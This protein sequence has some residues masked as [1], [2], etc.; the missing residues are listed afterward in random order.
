MTQRTTRDAPMIFA[1]VEPE[2][3]AAAQAIADEKYEGNLSMVVRDA[4]R[5]Y[6]ARW[7]K[8]RKTEGRAA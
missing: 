1:R 6:I 5:Q 8:Q 2:D 3:R 4:M 7:R